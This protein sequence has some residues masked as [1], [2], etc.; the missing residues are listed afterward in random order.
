[1]ERKRESEIDAPR[2]VGR[3]LA[4]RVRAMASRLDGEPEA[5][6]EGGELVLGDAAEHATDSSLVDRTKVV[7][8]GVRRLGEAALAWR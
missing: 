4:L 1:M 2:Q 3:E 5:L 8:E 6:V 7:D